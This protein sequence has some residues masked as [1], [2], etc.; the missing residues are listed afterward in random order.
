L[1]NPVRALVLF[2]L[3]A[4]SAPALAGQ[5]NV[6]SGVIRV[7]LVVSSTPAAATPAFVAT[8]AASYRTFLT[9]GRTIWTRT[10]YY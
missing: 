3:L 9:R 4:S 8:T 2:L 6:A 5:A 10:I 7:G 1:V